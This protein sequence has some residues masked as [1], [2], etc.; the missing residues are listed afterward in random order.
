PDIEIPFLEFTGKEDLQTVGA[1]RRFLIRYQTLI[2]FPALMSVTIGL[3]RK[4]FAFLLHNRTKYYAIEWLTLIAHLVLY[5]TLVFYCLNVWQGLIFI[6]IHQTLSGLY[7]GS[8]FA[9][10]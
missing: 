7:L 1:F 10:N 8:I 4:S 6:F 9:P 5:F 3:Q 2:F